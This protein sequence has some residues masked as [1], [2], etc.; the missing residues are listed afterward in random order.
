MGYVKLGYDFNSDTVRVLGPNPTVKVMPSNQFF[1]LRNSGSGVGDFYPLPDGVQM[2]NN[3][4]LQN[5]RILVAMLSGDLYMI[6][7]EERLGLCLFHY[8]RKTGS[9]EGNRWVYCDERPYRR[10]QTEGRVFLMSN[11]STMSLMQLANQPDRGG[12]AQPMSMSGLAP[13]VGLGAPIGDGVSGTADARRVQREALAN[14]Y[15]AGYIMGS[16]P[17]LTLSLTKH[18]QK[19]SAPTFSIA[20]K[21]SKPSRCLAVLISMPA[22]CCK[23]GGS[24]ATPTEIMNGM[25]DF[26]T[27]GNGMVHQAFQIKAAISYIAALGGSM[28]EYAPTAVGAKEQWS[29][30]AILSE[31]NDV[32]YVRVHATE[33]K[34]N[35]G[36]I[37]DRFRFSLRSTHPRRSLYTTGN[38]VCLRA[39]EHMPVKCTTEEDAYRLN[40]AAFGG[41]RYR[42]P[43]TETESALEKAFHSCP[44]QIWEKRYTVDGQEVTGIGSAF[45]MAGTEE[46]NDG[47]VSIM[48]R[49]LSYF[50]WYQTGA[51]R[52][53]QPTPVR[54]MVRRVLKPAEGN[55]KE[56]MVTVPI[57]YK[58]KPDDKAFV[59]YRNFVNMIVAQGY[60]TQDKL[61][62][63]GGRASK[64]SKKKQQLT[65]DQ[66]RSL[67][68]FLNDSDVISAIQ[69]VQ[70]A[71]ADHDVL[72]AE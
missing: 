14:S 3:G 59:S 6:A 70:E 62:S 26:A 18:K 58:E 35:K 40:E 13:S 9:S 63:M 69:A 25:V 56:R 49:E 34:S 64:T 50:P 36:N 60:I 19:D 15:V 27:G 23:K 65:E 45:F 61:L 72:H 17:A 31:H 33:N 53:A 57:L 46:T 12:V 44:D 52:P 66:K 54:H 48:R 38:I 24:L 30:E 68:Q 2:W 8:V 43:K 39:L 4:E 16:A 71:S 42:K 10:L 1:A 32:S 7:D 47:G 67:T 20:A 5:E 55:R 22:R 21:E 29:K 11:P 41:W 51:L 37:Q 28:A